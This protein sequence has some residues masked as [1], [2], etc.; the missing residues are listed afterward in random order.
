MVAGQLNGILKHLQTDS[1]SH[2]FIKLLKDVLFNAVDF[3]VLPQ[4]H[5]AILLLLDHSLFFLDLLHIFLGAAHYIISGL[6]PHKLKDCLDLL[7]LFI[8]YWHYL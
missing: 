8:N 2:L 5:N 1:A 4:L 6:E 7:D 3:L